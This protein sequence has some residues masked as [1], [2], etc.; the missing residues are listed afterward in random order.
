MNRYCFDEVERASLERLNI[1]MAIY[2][3]I[4]KRV[5]T[6]LVT[7]G[8]CALMGMERPAALCGHEGQ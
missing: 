2:Q 4:D 6:L 8:L 5:V 3:F 1:A 7:D